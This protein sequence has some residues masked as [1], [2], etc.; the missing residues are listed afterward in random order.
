MYE[1]REQAT[2]AHDRAAA[3]YE[4]L[5]FHWTRKGDIRRA[6]LA[7]RQARLHLQTALFELDRLACSQRA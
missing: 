1:A 5:A 2:E 3:R 7:H 4:R 6:A